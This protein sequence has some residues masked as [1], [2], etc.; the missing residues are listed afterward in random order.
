MFCVA[1]MK[2]P[3]N[4]DNLQ[5]LA[6]WLHAVRD[7]RSSMSQRTRKSIDAH[8]GMAVAAVEA[9]KRNLHLLELT[10]DK[11]RTLIAASGSPFKIIC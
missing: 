4:N 9:R 10:D 2:S 8:G 3:T 11:N 6:S 1:Q 7:G 5:W